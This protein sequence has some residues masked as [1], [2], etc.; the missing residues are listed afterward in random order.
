MTPDDARVRSD[1]EDRRGKDGDIDLQHVEERPTDTEAVD[2]AEDGVT[3]VAAL[4]RR[5]GE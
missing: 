5:Q 4:V 2:D 1:E 3:L